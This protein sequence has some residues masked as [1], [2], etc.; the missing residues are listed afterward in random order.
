MDSAW[1]RVEQDLEGRRKTPDGGRGAGPVKD[2]D[3]DLIERLGGGL[4]KGLGRRLG[5]GLD[6]GLGVGIG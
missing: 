1:D 2:S 6:H 3:D 4:S 5:A